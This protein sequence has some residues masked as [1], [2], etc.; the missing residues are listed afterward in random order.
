MKTL[1][2]YA[3]KHG[4]TR[5]IAQRIAKQIEQLDE[6]FESRPESWPD[7]QPDGRPGA[8][9]KAGGAVSVAI[10]DLKQGGAPSLGQFDRVIIGASIYAGMARK[11]AKTYLSQNA[12][13]LLGMKYGLFLSGMDVSKEK[14]FFE[15]N[16][17]PDIR[18]SAK[19]TAFL[20]G[21]FDPKKAGAIERLIMK[22]VGKRTE[23][24]DT[25]DDEKIA[26]FVEE[27]AL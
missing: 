5:D 20:G 7:G 22:A 1:I 13:S 12:G 2:L 18:R 17:S 9:G 10:H 8:Q 11:E 3:T 21:V 16:F 23:Y 24:I 27:M 4:A 25:I 15:A 19:A 6:R 14:E 26:R